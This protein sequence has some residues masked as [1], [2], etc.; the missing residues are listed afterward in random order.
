MIENK[1]IEASKANNEPF[2]LKGTT[3]PTKKISSNIPIFE[4]PT[5]NLLYNINRYALLINKIDNSGNSIPLG[6]FCFGSAFIL[7]GIYECK[8][9]LFEEKSLNIYILLFGGLGQL[10]SG[11]LEYI[12]GR[13]FPANLY[14][15]YGIYFTCYFALQY[16]NKYFNDDCKTFFYGTW[17]GLTFPLF[18]GSFQTNVFYLIQ[19]LI[20][21][22]FFIVRCIGEAKALPKLKEVTSGVLEIVTGIVSLYICFSQII[23]E[24]F[25][26][27]LLPSLSLAK[28]NEIDINTQPTLIVNNN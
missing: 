19:T 8:N 20:G 7:Y 14:L 4:D 27:P 12:K 25:R 13:T 2:E 10:L 21:C 3:V 15:I 24:T 5:D 9:D 18:L 16:Q 11:I 23:N 6:A 1:E 28:D 17:A 22:A 26:F